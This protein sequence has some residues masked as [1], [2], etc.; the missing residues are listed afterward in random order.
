MAAS[1]AGRRLRER[2]AEVFAPCRSGSLFPYVVE[3]DRRGFFTLSDNALDTPGEGKKHGESAADGRLDIGISSAHMN[4]GQV[5]WSNGWRFE[6]T[7]RE[8]YGDET[9]RGYLAWVRV[10]DEPPRTSNAFRCAG[11][12]EGEVEQRARQW[13]S[14]WKP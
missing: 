6:L 8:V 14:A 10:L 9:R 5:V 1:G 7:I 13:I 4:P 11:W 2:L 12:S 3:G